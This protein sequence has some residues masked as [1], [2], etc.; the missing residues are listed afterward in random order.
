MVL[1]IAGSVLEK[2]SLTTRTAM[3]ALFKVFRCG[4]ECG[5]CFWCEVGPRWET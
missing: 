1:F 4:P 2:Q 5:F 3:S